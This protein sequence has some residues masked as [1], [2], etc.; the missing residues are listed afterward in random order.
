MFV[1]GAVLLYRDKI[2]SFDIFFPLSS[3]LVGGSRNRLRFSGTDAATRPVGMD[4]ELGYSGGKKK[5]LQL[6]GLPSK[7]GFKIVKQS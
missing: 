4:P 6:F 3:L 5:T 2:E 7:D 1:C